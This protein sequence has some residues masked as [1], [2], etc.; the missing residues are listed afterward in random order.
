MKAKFIIPILA[1]AAVV[2][3]GLHQLPDGN[4]GLS[5]LTI[6]NIEA[7]TESVELKDVIIMC[8]WQ[9]TG[10]QCYKSTFQLK[11]CKEYMYYECLFTGFQ[12]DHCKQPSCM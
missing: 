6:E 12:T 9:P 5:N 4:V 11:M 10:G 8:D 1:A 2:G 7:L 3:I